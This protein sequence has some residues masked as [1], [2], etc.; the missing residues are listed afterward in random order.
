MTDPKNIEHDCDPD[1]CD[2]DQED[3][4]ENIDPWDDMPGDWDYNR[5]IE[6]AIN[7]F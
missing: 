7:K 3:D 4:Q 1:I 5:N 6:L 2:C